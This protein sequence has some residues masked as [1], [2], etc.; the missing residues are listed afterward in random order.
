MPTSEP[1]VVGRRVSILTG[2]SFASRG[3]VP[4]LFISLHRT[5]VVGRTPFGDEPDLGSSSGFS[6]VR[7]SE[8]HTSLS[9]RPLYKSPNNNI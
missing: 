4:L 7:G 6:I 8:G 1:I 3:R 9:L 2:R 5:E